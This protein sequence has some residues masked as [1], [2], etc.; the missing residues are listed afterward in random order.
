[1][2]S[3]ILYIHLTD[4]FLQLVT[5][6]AASEASSGNA[7]NDTFLVLPNSHAIHQ[8]SGVPSTSQHKPKRKLAVQLSQ[9]VGKPNQCKKSAQHATETESSTDAGH[10]AVMPKGGSSLSQL[11]SILLELRLQY[12]ATLLNALYASE[13]PFDDFQKF[14]PVFLKNSYTAFESVWLHL[15]IRVET[16]DVLFNIVSLIIAN[17]ICNLC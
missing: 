8:S 3:F 7:T 11:P 13:K 17:D 12:F 4:Q 16:D 15:R 6:G 14:S 9:E 2:L 10:N 1:M 5:P